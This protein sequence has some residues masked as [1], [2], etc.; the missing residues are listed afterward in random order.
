MTAI[1]EYGRYVEWD[2]RN[3]AT[4]P[5]FW[6]RNTS[7]DLRRCEALE[8][9]SRHGG[10]SL[11]LAQLGARV[12]CTDLEGP[13]ERARVCHSLAGVAGRVRYESLDVTDVGYEDRFDVVVFKSVL[14][15]LGGPDR[16]ATQTRAVAQLHR[17]LRAGG[18]L[19]FA[20]NLSASP[21]H[22]FLRR[23]FVDWGRRW[24]YV[25]I[26]EMLGF[27][28]PFREVTYR[29]VGLCGAL[30]RSQRQRALLGA[31]DRAFLDRLVPESWRYIMI[32]VARK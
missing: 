31:V 22:Q 23:R 15:A 2:V 3:W 8:V 17:S 18:E 10:L 6:T 14:G 26:A 29:T 28:A 25:S 1:T 16:L 24:R 21:A 9:G 32:G 30:G 5:E 13:S 11:W 27:L 4:A 12:L 7:L 20:E 19:F